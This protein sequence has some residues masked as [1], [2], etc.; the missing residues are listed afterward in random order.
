MSTD[1]ETEVE[2]WHKAM[3]ETLLQTPPPTPEQ[4]D[5]F[6]EAR[7][8]SPQ[9][10]AEFINDLMVK[11][12]TA[13]LTGPDQSHK[14]SQSTI[15][16]RAGYELRQAQI[17]RA[18]Q[19]QAFLAELG[20]Y[21]V[22]ELI[23]THGVGGVVDKYNLNRM[24]FQAWIETALG[25]EIISRAEEMFAE[26]LLHG[27]LTTL[28]NSPDD[29]VDATF[30]KTV[31]Q[32]KTEL[33]GLFNRKRARAAPKIDIA[34]V[35]QQAVQVSV[36]TGSGQQLASDTDKAQRQ[37]A[38]AKAKVQYGTSNYKDPPGIQDWLGGTLQIEEHLV[39]DY[40][41]LR[42]TP[43]NVP[44][45]LE[46]IEGEVV[47]SETT[48]TGKDTQARDPSRDELE[49]NDDGLLNIPAEFFDTTDE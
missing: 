46:V 18:N 24:E 12:G 23:A 44:Q 39:Q 36:Y 40:L 10:A 49:L 30:K 47:A 1:I 33:A 34:A 19:A 14:L 31:T 4:V 5:N 25:D 11:N 48:A 28:E 13:R 6:A 37:I 42:W 20:P 21:G 2:E 9:E 27:A 38:L 29:I 16:S 43:D 3:H 41:M 35:H 22:A 32:A 7:S 17:K 15:H 45:Q 8:R 26:G